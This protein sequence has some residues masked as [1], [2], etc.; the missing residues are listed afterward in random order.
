MSI[1]TAI[2]L[3]VSMLFGAPAPAM[4]QPTVQA[5]SVVSED[6]LDYEATRIEQEQWL[7]AK[8]TEAGIELPSNVTIIFHDGLENCGDML[9]PS[10]YGGGCTYHWHDGTVSVLL[11]ATAPTDQ[12]GAHLLFHELGHALHNLGE[13]GAEYYA[14]HYDHTP[15]VWAYQECDI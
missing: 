3:T 12:Y 5:S 15:T 4:V 9:S 1:I 13:C 8:L 2:L 14:H 11:S 6:T 10:S 7:S